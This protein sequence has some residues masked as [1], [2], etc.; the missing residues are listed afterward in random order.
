MV[1]GLGG[2]NARQVDG[3]RESEVFRE[4]LIGDTIYWL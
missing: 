3:C 4:W 1:W 2:R